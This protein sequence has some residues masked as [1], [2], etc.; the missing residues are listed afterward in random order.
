MRF[1]ERPEA[2]QKE[3]KPASGML[4]EPVL[5]VLKSI[6]VFDRGVITAAASEDERRQ[7]SGANG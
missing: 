7:A 2:I 4:A 6:R 3:L 1:V 5:P